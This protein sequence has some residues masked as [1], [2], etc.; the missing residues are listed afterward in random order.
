MSS[1]P[2]A[3]VDVMSKK[4][5]AEAVTD[6]LVKRGVRHIFGVPGGDCNLDFIEAAQRAGITFVLTR[7]ETSAA[8]MASVQSE[9]TGSIGVLMTTRGPGLANGV[10]GIAYASLDRASLLVMADDYD[11]GTEFISHQRFDQTA[12]LAPLVKAT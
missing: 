10:N 3:R 8:I 1:S 11:D 12:L 4:N 9:L 5:I 6:V 7:T 2:V